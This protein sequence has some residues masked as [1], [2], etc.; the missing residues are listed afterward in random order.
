MLY[1]PLERSRCG[2]CGLLDVRLALMNTYYFD[3]YLR[4]LLHSLVRMD[5]ETN[6]GIELHIGAVWS[7][8]PQYPRPRLSAQ[9]ECH[10]PMSVMQNGAARRMA[11]A[12]IKFIPPLPAPDMV[13]SLS[14]DQTI[15]DEICPGALDWILRG[16]PRVTTADV[17]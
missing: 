14:V 9:R 1:A 12:S 7:D 13:T 17:E 16:L 10:H 5:G 2:E 11:Q 6:P 15:T 8:D 3:D 4:L